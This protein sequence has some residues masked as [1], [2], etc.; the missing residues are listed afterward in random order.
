MLEVEFNRKGL[1][2]SRLGV[3]L[4]HLGDED[5]ASLLCSRIYV[6]KKNVSVVLF[7]FSFFLRVQA[8]FLP[9]PRSVLE[10]SH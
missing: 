8:G 7:F 2:S 4:E 6:K 3:L 9:L 1:E 5:V 10:E